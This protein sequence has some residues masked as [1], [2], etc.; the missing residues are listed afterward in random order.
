MNRKLP[1]FRPSL[2]NLALTIKACEVKLC[3]ENNLRS[4]YCYFTIVNEY[5]K[6]NY[7]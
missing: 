7:D 4:D 6:P 5:T 2:I 3:Y 1:P